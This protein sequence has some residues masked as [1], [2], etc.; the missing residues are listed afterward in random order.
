M[1]NEHNLRRLS[2]SEAR[3]IGKTG[4]IKSGEARRER[5]AARHF[6]Q[7]FLALPPSAKNIEILKTF[8]LPEHLIN[9]MAVM[10]V[11]LIN[12][13]FS[14]DPRCVRLALEI[15]GELPVPRQFV[16]PLT[17]IINGALPPDED[18]Y[19]FAAL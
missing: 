3:E 15:A 19:R 14:G 1:A 10:L 18:D 7:A 13:G 9:N 8:G 5:S 11:G 17:V 6:I 16:P 2:T 12:K 4:G